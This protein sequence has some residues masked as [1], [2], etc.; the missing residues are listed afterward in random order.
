MLRA[1]GTGRICQGGLKALNLSS[2]LKFCFELNFSCGKLIGNAR[3]R[4]TEA[5]SRSRPVSVSSVVT[6]EV[7]RMERS[8]GVARKRNDNRSGFRVN[9]R[10]RKGEKS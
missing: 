1:N 10:S 3:K 5:R 2:E 7:C 4:L 6:Y 8:E 9:V